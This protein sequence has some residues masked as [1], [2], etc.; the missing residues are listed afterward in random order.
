[1]FYPGTPLPPELNPARP[2]SLTEPKTPV[3][4]YKLRWALS[5][6]ALC[7]AALATDASFVSQPD[8]NAS[9]DCS[10]VDRVSLREIGGVELT[11]LDTRCQT[12]LRLAVWVKHGIR[13]AAEAHFGVDAAR[14]HHLNSYNCR[15]IRTQA[16]ESSRMSTHATADA[17]DI[18]GVT[19]VDGTRISLLES[20][21]NDGPKS[22]FLNDIRDAAC[23]WFRVTLGPEFNALHADH[24]HLQHTGWGLCK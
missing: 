17:V 11:P 19:L 12:A 3:T 4:E 24:F 18:T 16:G 8:L 10:I 13:P 20:W 6:G 7:K 23:D 2:F 14:V 15:R 9:A 21:T 5:D 22:A 1:M